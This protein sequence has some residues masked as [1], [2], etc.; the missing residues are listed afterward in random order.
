MADAAQD[1]ITQDQIVEIM[2]GER[3]VMMGSVSESG[4]IQTHPM[5]PQQVDEDADVWFFITLDGDQ[6]QQLRQTPEVNLAFAET[7]SW[8]SVSGTVEFVDDRAMIEEL[9]NDS[10][11]AYFPQ[12]KDDPNLGLLH[13]KSESAQFWGIPGGK[14]NA[15]AQI[16][17]NKVTGKR[18]SGHSDTVE[19]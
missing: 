9:W 13:F 6:A 1:G 7:G 2:R 12:G 5:T 15:L 18:A 10:A 11:K 17:K 14:A 19:L 4:K 3:F 8:L 16:V